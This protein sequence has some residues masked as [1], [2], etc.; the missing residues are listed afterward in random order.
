M[1]KN[2]DLKIWCE[3]RYETINKGEL[4]LPRYGIPFFAK[5]IRW[6]TV[7]GN[8]LDLHKG[9]R[10]GW[11]AP[12]FGIEDKGSQYFL[13]NDLLHFPEMSDLLYD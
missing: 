4:A 10:R 11:I 5:L 9:T 8:T 3:D 12:I 13:F 6:A 1:T 7:F 2:E